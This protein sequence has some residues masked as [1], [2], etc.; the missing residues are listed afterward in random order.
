[1]QKAKTFRLKVKVLNKQN[2]TFDRPKLRAQQV[3][4]LLAMLS[5]QVNLYGGSPLGEKH[6]D[7]P[8]NSDVEVSSA[9]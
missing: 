6:T 1:M 9:P 7:R 5:K 3:R 4:L 2:E 8:G